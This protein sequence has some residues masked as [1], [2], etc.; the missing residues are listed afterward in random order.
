MG[1]EG[2][3][4]NTGQTVTRSRKKIQKV[5]NLDPG[6]NT[7]R[8]HL[9]APLDPNTNTDT[10]T[11][12]LSLTSRVAG[13][14]GFGAYYVVVCRVGVMRLWLC[15]V[16]VMCLC[17]IR[18]MYLC[19]CR[20]WVLCIV[21]THTRLHINTLLIAA[22]VTRTFTLTPTRTLPHTNIQTHTQTRPRVECTVG[23][24]G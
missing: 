12:S 11:L 22:S 2:R 3:N 9:S 7:N 10:L 24:L 18:V 20:I 13:K 6:K 21:H 4:T 16:R 8:K 5:G 1:L 23:W 19:L 15:R 14:I 17:R